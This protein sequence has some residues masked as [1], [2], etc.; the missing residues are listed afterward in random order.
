MVN[1]ES[2]PLEAACEFSLPLCAGTESSVAATKSFIATL[3]A[4]A[5]L[6]AHWKEDVELLEAGLALPEALRVRRNRTGAWPSMSCAIAS[7]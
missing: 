7:A 2:S 6:V 5:R 4:S 3:S 1:A